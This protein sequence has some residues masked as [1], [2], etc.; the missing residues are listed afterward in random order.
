MKY[1]TTYHSTSIFCLI[2]R[3]AGFWFFVMLFFSLPSA[4]AQRIQFSKQ[5]NLIRYVTGTM[6]QAKCAAD[7]NGDGLD[8]IT[9]VSEN[10]ILLIFSRKMELLNISF[11]LYRFKHFLNGVSVPVT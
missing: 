10:G 6:G 11:F 9:R 5:T 3:R 4:N 1:Q 7:M 2:G 8:D